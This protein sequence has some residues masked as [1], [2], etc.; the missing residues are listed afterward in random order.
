VVL[1]TLTIIL[2]LNSFLTIGLILNENETKKDA[3][4]NSMINEVSN[5]LESLTWFCIIF[6]FFLFL[7]EAKVGNF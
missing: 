4:T 6:E 3:I 7:I 5:P 1:D 2:L